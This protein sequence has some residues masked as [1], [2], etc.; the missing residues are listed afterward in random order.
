MIAYAY[1]Y[2]IPFL[3]KLPLLDKVR[4]SLVLNR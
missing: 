2:R 4:L 3:G 1:R